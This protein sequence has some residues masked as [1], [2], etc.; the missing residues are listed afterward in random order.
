[1]RRRL[2]VLLS[3]L[4]LLLGGSLLAAPAASAHPYCAQV[5]GSTAKGVPGMSAGQLTN[6]RAGRHACFDRLV[7]DVDRP[8]TAWSVRYVGQVVMDGSGAVVPVRGGARLEVVARVNVLPT[9]AFFVGSGRDLVNTAGYR[10]FRQVAWAGSF[11]GVS[12]VALGVRARL[13][14]R[15]FVLPGPGAGSRLVVD[16]GHQ[17][18]APGHTDC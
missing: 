13:P 9:D 2:L 8:L 10:T 16:V 14:F 15:A 17:W 11:E 5:W 6:V 7:L 12:T 3:V 4:S 18:C 1:M